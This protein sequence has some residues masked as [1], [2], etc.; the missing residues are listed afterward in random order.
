MLVSLGDM[1]QN[2]E[3]VDFENLDN[4]LFTELPFP[5]F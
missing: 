1:V 5:Y 3:Q 4:T 2:S